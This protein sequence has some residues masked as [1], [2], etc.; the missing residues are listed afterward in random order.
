MDLFL[1]AGEE[2]TTIHFLKHQIEPT[3][4][5]EHSEHHVLFL[6]L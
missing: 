3:M 2:G 1:E 5:N 6:F 4:K